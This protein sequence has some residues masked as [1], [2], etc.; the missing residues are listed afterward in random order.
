MNRVLRVG[1]RSV[2][3]AEARAT[4]ARL[5]LLSDYPGEVADWK[6]QKY[7]EEDK[8]FDPAL[9][10]VIKAFQQSRGVLPTGVIDEL[11][12]RELRQASYT[13]GAR[14]LFYEPGSELVG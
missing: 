10:E 11:T 5:G 13:L 2:R 1:D 9:S 3:V 6:R 4:L 7:S 12:L 8:Y 14:V